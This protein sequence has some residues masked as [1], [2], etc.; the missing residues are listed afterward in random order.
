M[1]YIIVFIYLC[2]IKVGNDARFRRDRRLRGSL[3]LH[4]A[5]G[6]Q[7][8]EEGGGHGKAA[9]DEEGGSK[10]LLMRENEGIVY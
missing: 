7:Q 9:K 2:E 5:A 4:E 6:A 3:L 8:E 1:E 10:N